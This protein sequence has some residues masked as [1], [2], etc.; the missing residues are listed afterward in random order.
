MASHKERGLISRGLVNAGG[1]SGLTVSSMPGP[2]IAF[3][4]CSARFNHTLGGDPPKVML[5]GESLTSPLHSVVKFFTQ[6]QEIH[7]LVS[8]THKFWGPLAST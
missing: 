2:I 4:H 3:L 8:F 7:F 5:A 6:D 1:L